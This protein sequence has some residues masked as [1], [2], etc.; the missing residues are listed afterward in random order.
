MEQRSSTKQHN[1]NRWVSSLDLNI[2]R[3]WMSWMFDGREFQS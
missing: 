3:E 1:A 2:G